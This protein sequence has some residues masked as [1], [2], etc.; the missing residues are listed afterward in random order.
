M[1]TIVLTTKGIATT[2]WAVGTIHQLVRQSTGDLFSETK[3]PKPTVT[4]DTPKG[5]VAAKS[6]KR[7]IL[8]G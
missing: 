6:E 8:L 5:N 4:A 1:G 2:E 7:L 3:I